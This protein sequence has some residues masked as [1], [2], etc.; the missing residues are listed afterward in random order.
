MR[1]WA[2]ARC[3][4][5]NWSVY[6]DS[7]KRC[8]SWSIWFDLEM[9]WTRPPS[10]KRSRQQQF[11]ETAIQA[12]L[13]LSPICYAT[14]ASDRVCGKFAATGQAELGSVGF[15]HPVSAPRLR[16]IKLTAHVTRVSSLTSDPIVG[17]KP[18]PLLVD[19]CR[20]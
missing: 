11:S 14:S 9:V 4:T 12:C 17:R 5:M 16:L 7:L 2:P 6:S 18:L 1:S 8:G 19:T 13:T 20:H 10:G 3:K 15:H